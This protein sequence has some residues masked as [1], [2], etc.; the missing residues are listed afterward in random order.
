MM[1][2]RSLLLFAEKWGNRRDILKIN[3]KNSEE[4]DSL[5]YVDKTT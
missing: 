4:K 2:S 5:G 3:N 1:I